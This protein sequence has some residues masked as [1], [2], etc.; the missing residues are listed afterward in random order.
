MT[1]PFHS[2]LETGLRSLGVLSASYPRQFDLQRLVVFDHLIVHTGDLGGPASLHPNLPMRPAELLVRRELVERGVMLMISRGLIERVVN[3]K[4]FS[5]Q[6]SEFASIFLGSLTSDYLTELGQRAKWVAEN[7]GERTDDEIRK[8][9][10]GVFDKW[11]S[12]FAMPESIAEIL[13]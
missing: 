4:G 5:Y 10:E 1:S 9:T 2:P 6:A 11:I 8:L 12:E 13:V 3:E 7:F